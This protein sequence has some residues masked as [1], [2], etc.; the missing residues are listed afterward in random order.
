MLGMKKKLLILLTIPFLLGCNSSKPEDTP[1]EPDEPTPAPTPEPEPE[2]EPEPKPEIETETV[3]IVFKNNFNKYTIDDNKY[4]TF[5][6]EYNTKANKEGLLTSI[7]TYG[8]VQIN[9]FSQGYTTMSFGSQKSDGQMK[10]VFSKTILEIEFTVQAYFKV[11]GSYDNGSI[12]V[13]EKEETSLP[14][15]SSQAAPEEV[16][17]SYEIE[18]NHFKFANK[19]AGKRVFLNSMKVTY[20]V[21]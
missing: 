2:P 1:T 7:Q 6:D 4:Q 12:F 8:P 15:G 20:A 19:E 9:E 11:N 5:V 21:E 10:M 14:A 16:T 3:E 13:F 17:A 18:T